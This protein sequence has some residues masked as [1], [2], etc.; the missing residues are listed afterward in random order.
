MQRN[1][2]VGQNLLIINCDVTASKETT[3]AFY[4]SSEITFKIS[5]RVIIVYRKATELNRSA[6][7]LFNRKSIS[8]HALRTPQ[9]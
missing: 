6:K 2:T 5:I 7:V 1:E 4:Q 3:N 9:F 8:R